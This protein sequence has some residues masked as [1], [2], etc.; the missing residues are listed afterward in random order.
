M[1]DG[2]GPRILVRASER[3]DAGGSQHPWN[4]GSEIHGW[5]LGQ[6]AGLTRL[7]VSL[8]WLPP[9][10]ESY[11]YHLHHREEEWM[12]LLEGEGVVDVDDREVAVGPGDFL[13]FPP[14]VAH[15]VRNTGAGD[16][17]FL[18]GGEVISD[19]E[20]ADFPRLKRRMVRV[21][22]KISIFPYEAEVP[23]FA[24]APT[25]LELP[26]ALFGGPA[27]EKA[28]PPRVVVKAAERGDARRFQHPQNPRSEVFLSGLSRP[29]GLKRLAVVHT[30]LPARRDA[31]VMH[32]H[33]RDEE[34]MYV[35]SGRGLARHAGIEVEI[36]PG[37]FL[38]FPAGV[39]HDTR[40]LDEELTYVS[41]G[42]AWAKGT[43]DVV[44]FPTLGLRRV[45]LGTKD[46]TTFPMSQALEKIGH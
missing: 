39:A 6:A 37:D 38:G 24:G 30:R 46:S 20:V 40:A 26:A 27:P 41:G 1:A 21:G 17:R 28:E 29:A 33:A 13:G 36:G 11:A 34:W 19:V 32:A 10:K 5:M 14:G 12:Y 31:Y 2:K 45:F 4:P 9:G 25:P 42:D 43:V 7:G 35:L 8:A 16:L 44:D 15:L 3:G 23:F 18:Q 22:R